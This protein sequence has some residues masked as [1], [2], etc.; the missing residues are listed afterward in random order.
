[1]QQAFDGFLAFAAPGQT[2]QDRE[3]VQQFEGAG[4]RVDAEFLR[5]VSASA[6]MVR[7]R[8]RTAPRSAEV[9]SAAYSCSACDTNNARGK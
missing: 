6:A 5:Q 7:I 8:S 3:V 1:V 2:L 4:L 9:V